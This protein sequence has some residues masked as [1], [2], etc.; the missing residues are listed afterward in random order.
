MLRATPG[1]KY[2]C[3]YVKTT[4]SVAEDE[5]DSWYPISAW[6]TAHSYFDYNEFI[7]YWLPLMQGN[8]YNLISFQGESYENAAKLD[9]SPAPDSVLRV[10]MAWKPLE[11]PI[12]IQPQ[13]LEPFVREDFTVVE[14]GGGRAAG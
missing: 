13:M 4:A 6:Y 9:I 5:T 3:T 2:A 11:E 1:S 14:W 10:F 7:V 8:K 12:A